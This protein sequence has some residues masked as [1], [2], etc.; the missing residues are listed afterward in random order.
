MSTSFSWLLSRVLFHSL[1]DA[2]SADPCSLS[3]SLAQPLLP[4]QKLST[5]V[6]AT[7]ATT[8]AVLYFSTIGSQ[9]L[10]KDVSA[11]SATRLIILVFYI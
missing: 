11:L 6:A 10:Q 3:L 1:A 4:Q 7:L 5:H 2:E 8:S 9:D